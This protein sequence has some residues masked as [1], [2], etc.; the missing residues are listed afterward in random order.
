M[1]AYVALPKTLYEYLDSELAAHLAHEGD[2]PPNV[3]AT[4]A[5][6]L[7]ERLAACAAYIPGRLVSNQL[8]DPVPG[9]VSGDFW[10]GSLLFADL[11]GFTSLSEQLSVLGKQGAEEISAVV[12]HLFNALVDEVLAHQGALLKFGGDA[13]TAFFDAETL[14][15]HHA[16]AATL[17]ALA[18]QERMQ[19][20]AALKTRK[21]TFC[22][23][24]RV[25]VHSGEVF[26]AEVGDTSH[27]ELVVTGPEVNRVATAQE[28]AAPGEV[29]ISDYTA[30]LLQ[31]A[32]ITPR[33]DGFQHITAL[34]P[35]TIPSPS[36]DIVP[37]NGPDD[38][39]T[40][41][42]LATQVA[43]L[44]PYL[45]RGLPGR[46][47]D[48]SVS[49]VGEFRPVSVL[50]AN[51]YDFSAMLSQLRNDADKAATILNAYFRRAQEVVHRYDGIVNKVD[52]YTHGDKLMVLFGAPTTH[53]DDPL[54]AV[55]CALELE[56][57]LAEANAEIIALFPIEDV[58]TLDEQEL[59]TNHSTNHQHV[60]HQ[61]IG[62]NTGTVFAGRVGGARRYEYTVMGSA[63]NL[64]ARLMSAAETRMVLV[65]PATRAVVHRQIALAEHAPLTLKGLAAP[66]IP[67]RALHVLESGQ[68][69]RSGDV[70]LQRAPLVGRDAI[71]DMMLQQ[72]T[73]ALQGAG[74]VVALVGEAGIGKS[75][76][77]EELIH[78]LVMAGFTEDA[79]LAVPDFQIYGNDCQSY[80]QTMSYANIR[81]PL[82][83]LLGLTSHRGDTSILG[84]PSSA[85]VLNVLEKS[86]ETFAPTLVRFT[87]LLS[88]VLGISLPESPL[89]RALSGE[90]RHNRLTEFMVAIFRGAS[91]VTPLLLSFEDIQWSDASS[92]EILERLTHKIHDVPLLLLLNYRSEPPIEAP[93]CNL[94]TTTCLGL[95]EL[96]DDDSTKLLEAMLDGTPPPEMLSLLERTQGNPFFTEELVRT[97]V[98]SDVLVRNET[99]TWE[100][101]QP[102]DNVA[103][104]SSVEGLIYSRLDRL[105]EP[106]YDLV[107]VASVIGRR[108]RYS[109][110]ANIYTNPS[111]LESALQGLIDGEIIV[112]EDHIEGTEDDAIYLF[113][114]ALLRDVAYEGV[115]YARRRELH[116]NV[117]RCLTDNSATYDE[118]LSLIAQ[119]FLLA[120]EWLNAFFYYK[121]AGIQAQKRYTNRD[122]LTLFSTALDIATHLEQQDQ[123]DVD[124]LDGQT[125][126]FSPKL[127]T[128][129]FTQ[130]WFEPLLPIP[131][132]IAELH[133]R[134]GYICALLGEPERA[135]TLYQE[136]LRLNTHYRTESQ[137]WI[138]SPGRR[139]IINQQV[140]L[141]M[142]RLHR[143]L[144]TLKEQR[145]CYEAAFDLLGK[146]MTY[147]SAESRDE[148]ARCYL[149][150]ARI[151]YSQG[152]F[153]R[154]LEWAR[155][156]LKIAEQ[157]GSI[158]SQ[159][160][161]LRRMGNLWAEQGDFPQSITTLQ[162]ACDL[163]EQAAYLTGLNVALNDLGATYDEFGR[164]KEAINCYGRSL[165]ISESVG[166]VKILALT[167]NNLA[168]TLVGRNELQ[169]ASDMYRYSREQFQR[170]G[171]EQYVALTTLN[172]GEVLLLQGKP[173]EALNLLQES[174]EIME[175]TNARLDLSEALRLAAEAMLELSDTKQATLY[176]TR[177]V[178]VAHELG[179]ATKE[180]MAQRVLGQI[181]LAEQDF[182]PAT[183][184]LKQSRIA[185]EQLDNRYELGKVFYWQARLAHASDALEQVEP[186]LQ[187]AEQIFQELD[188]QRDLTMVREF[189][190]FESLNR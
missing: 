63:V 134:K 27:I 152:E 118:N 190:T 166:D 114:H 172:L 149:L 125:D 28:I 105:D 96:S 29:V 112:I 120:E 101:T 83:Q 36:K 91:H 21:G 43:A 39:A 131:I 49:E 35:V 80:E 141:S 103:I 153:A 148:M 12:N 18:M 58:P 128:S 6:A 4:L 20:F 76:L 78:R 71:L 69:G 95:E 17:A 2:L 16:A 11:S 159:A 174:I 106:L 140:A 14:G 102:V 139:A 187:Q 167:S 24:L 40:L 32:S 158:V 182:T 15:E 109:T 176:A 136:A 104:P 31:N 162:R 74:R 170:I 8:T 9:R 164:W 183:A 115:L 189:R 116:C 142:V 61:S 155:M 97:L 65:S 127:V 138:M 144:A 169:R 50:F 77:I 46:F 13:L 37:H 48:A 41:E 26:A 88:D 126:S 25:G 90:Q 111:L 67:S 132:Q 178:D 147:A 52:M 7:R 57:A 59:S 89:T 85:G 10:H 145:A 86:V 64:S 177:S 185:L 123:T 73:T 1:N 84:D 79:E 163:F 38:I 93:W 171:S 124:D 87:P 119:H 146:G 23:R 34:P 100:F 150:G 98:D 54:R 175:R 92:L 5:T 173:V 33:T 137:K 44:H 42:L 107:Q 161:A 154:S 180:A 135:E 130:H 157:T 165:Q 72:S 22:L 151:Y 66:V 82:R 179:M 184:Y 122:A 70:A 51:F 30:K 75:R 117:A 133:E 60:L 94:P 108:F 55:R 181:A 188:A 110:L 45:V 81:K 186:L 113:R 56:A 143:H 68:I 62:I 121:E 160:Q 53:E 3:R 47:L 19:A 168:L 129:L 156:G 99:G